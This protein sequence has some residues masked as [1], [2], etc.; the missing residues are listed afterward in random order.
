MIDWTESMEQSF[1]Y[2][3]V[4]PNTWK[5]KTL[6][7]NIKSCNI[8]RDLGSETLGSASIDIDNAL[9]ECYIRIYLKVSQNGVNEKIPLGIFLVQTPSSNFDGMVRNVSMDAYTPL[10]ELK[11]K[12]VPLGYS[13]LKD[14]DILNEAFLIVRENCRAPV[15]KTELDEPKLLLNDFVANTDDNWLSFIRDLLAQAKYEYNLDEEG[16]ILFS[17]K[18]TI[19]QLQPVYTYNDDNVAGLQGGRALSVRERNDRM[20]RYDSAG[21]SDDRRP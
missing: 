5:D 12:K 8:K 6:I 2:Y 10:L 13:L 14:D 21:H 11:E 15:I 9:G 16:K 4:D 19:D 1:E 7:Q 18:Q 20:V 3:E 17:P